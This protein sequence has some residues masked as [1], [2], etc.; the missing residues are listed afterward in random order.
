[1]R[2]VSSVYGDPAKVLEREQEA[3]QRCYDCLHGCSRARCD[4][5][6]H[7]YP[8]EGRSTCHHF[9]FENPFAMS[10]E[11]EYDDVDAE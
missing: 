7:G 2:F 10:N 6:Q 3:G 8:D 11:T 5:K 9:I 4:K 1:M